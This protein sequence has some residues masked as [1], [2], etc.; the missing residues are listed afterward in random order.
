MKTQPFAAVVKRTQGT[1]FSWPGLMIAEMRTVNT[2]SL[3]QF[4]RYEDFTGHEAG[5]FQALTGLDVPGVEDI[6]QT[7][8]RPSLSAKG[9]AILEQVRN[10]LTWEEFWKLSAHLAETFEFEDDG[11]KLQFPDAQAEQALRL[12]YSSDIDR[13]MLQSRSSGGIMREMVVA[14]SV[15]ITE[16]DRHVRRSVA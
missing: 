16:S 1:R 15:T 3:F 7:R 8:V 6:I 2:G 12:K 13:L 4:W 9:V 11:G 5:I 14:P 10:I